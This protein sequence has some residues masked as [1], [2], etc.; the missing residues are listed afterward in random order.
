MRIDWDNILAGYIED[1]ESYYTCVVRLVKEFGTQKEV[2]RVL[3]INVRQITNL[4]YSVKHATQNGGAVSGPINHTKIFV[5]W[6]HD[7][8]SKNGVDIEEDELVE[9]LKG[10]E[11]QALIKA[12]LTLQKE[13]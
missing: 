8:L 1:E 9:F 12:K 13:V 4:M 7:W 11:G 6:V 2:A 10:D 5:G 3:G